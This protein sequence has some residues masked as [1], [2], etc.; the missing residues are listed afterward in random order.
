M[1]EAGSDMSVFPPRETKQPATVFVVKRLTPRTEKAASIAHSLSK[2]I[3]LAGLNVKRHSKE[4]GNC[5]QLATQHD[6]GR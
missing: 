2:K 5:Q 1:T 4:Q 6:P 3:G